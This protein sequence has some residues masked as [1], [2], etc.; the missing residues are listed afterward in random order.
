MFV[1]AEMSLGT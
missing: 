1:I